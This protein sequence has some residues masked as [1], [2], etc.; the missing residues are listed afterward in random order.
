MSLLLRFLR[1]KRHEFLEKEF[2][3]IKV[4]DVV[5]WVGLAIAKHFGVE[6]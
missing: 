2:P 4:N 6:E 1:F 5:E 3:M